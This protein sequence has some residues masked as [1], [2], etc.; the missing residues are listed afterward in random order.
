MNI[1]TDALAVL[2]LLIPGFMSSGILNAIVVRRAKGRVGSLIE[3]L[4]CSFLI[5]AT[6]HILG[7]GV[8]VMR[9]IEGSYTPQ[10]DFDHVPLALVLAIV[11]PLVLGAS[12]THDFHMRLLRKIGITAS[13]A[14]INTWLDI[15][16]D[17]S[18][19]KR[20]IIV[21]FTDERRLF[22]WPEYYSNDMDEGLIY[23]S[24]PSWITESGDYLDSGVQGILL[25]HKESIESVAFVDVKPVNATQ[26]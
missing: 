11:F 4:V 20:G 18:R 12:I 21:T 9:E 13:T 14:R 15:F 1:T 23:V 16:I 5:Y 25:T 3:A 7:F 8:V 26:Q 24:N 19:R 2:L 17:Q 22:G 10:V 6:L